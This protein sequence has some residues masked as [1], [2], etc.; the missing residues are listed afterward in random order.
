MDETTPA[1][2][3]ATPAAAPTSPAPM[4]EVVRFNKVTKTFGEGSHAKVAIQE[5]SF[6]IHDLPNKGELI[7]LV[8]PSGCGKSTLLRMLAGLR[9]HFPPT[10]GKL[11]VFGKPVAQPGADRG[12]VDQKYSLM[13]H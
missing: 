8:G 13:P 3:A 12:M 6:V 10:S 5:V 4:P 1:S 7:A 2:P 11:E 9:P